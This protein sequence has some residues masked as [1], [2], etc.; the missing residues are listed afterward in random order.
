MDGFKCNADH[1]CKKPCTA[2]EECK[3]FEECQTDGSCK[4]VGCKSNLECVLAASNP[5]VPLNGKDP[6]LAQC[7]TIKGV[8]VPTCAF[9]CQTDTECASDE[10]CSAGVCTKLGCTSDA[11]CRAAA[12]LPPQTVTADKPYVTEAKCVAVP[13]L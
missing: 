10:A 8:P 3:A 7:L 2:N 6:R 13:A 9:K 11:E 1:Q 12:N 4:L 5:G